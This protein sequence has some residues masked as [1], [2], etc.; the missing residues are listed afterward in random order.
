MILDTKVMKLFPTEFGRYVLDLDHDAITKYTIEFVQT[1]DSYT[2]YHDKKLN[3]AWLKGHS[4][5][6]KLH[7]DIIDA[8]YDYCKN[9]NRDMKDPFVY[10]WAS[11][12]HQGK[13]HGAHIHRKSLISGTYYPTDDKSHARISFDSPLLPLSM[14]DTKGEKSFI[15]SFKP[16]AGDMLMW[17]SFLTHRVFEQGPTDKPRV[18][19]SFNVDCRKIQNDRT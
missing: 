1:I 4:E 3:Q 2:T 13:A 18:A 11:V 16:K 5:V 17:P 6:R 14:H 10:M 15:Q 12:Y 7:K 9:T 8:S 19:I